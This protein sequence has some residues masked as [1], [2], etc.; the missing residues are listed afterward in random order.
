M[1]IYLSH[2]G[3]YNFESELY[4]PIKSSPLISIH[5]IFFPHE[6][7]NIGTN[8]KDLIAS[9][10]LLLAEVSHPSTGQGIELGWANANGT[11]ILCFHNASTKISNSIKF[12]AKDFVEYESSDDLL[13]KLQERLNHIV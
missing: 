6:R 3:N 10:D 12:V 7:E 9:A 8:S 11:Q 4:D 5:E 2:S 1:K 13:N